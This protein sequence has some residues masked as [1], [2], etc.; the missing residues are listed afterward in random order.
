M[1]DPNT[2][3]LNRLKVRQ[4]FLAA[5]NGA[6]LRGRAFLLQS[7]KRTNSLPA[8]ASRNIA[9]FGITVTKKVG[10]SVVRN[11]IRRRL[12]EVIR[13]NAQTCASAGSDY[14]LIAHKQSLH[15][16]F[17]A[18]VEDFMI[19]MERIS[20]QPPL[21]SRAQNPI[22]KTSRSMPAKRHLKTGGQAKKPE[23]SQSTGS[24]IHGK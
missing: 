10:N 14:V 3:Q 1:D 16:P 9:R 21:K 15:L 23:S 12:R 17:S 6:K 18:L 2:V 19:S 5:R 22:S 24:Q 20:K 8:D 7:I 11:R 4:D 13:L